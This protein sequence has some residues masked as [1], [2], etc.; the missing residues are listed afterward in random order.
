[1][2][3]SRTIATG[4]V[5]VLIAVALIASQFVS[6][7]GV[8]MGFWPV[9]GTIACVLVLIV[10]VARLR[11]GV[12]FMV[13]LALLYVL[14][15]AQF[16]W[17]MVGVW[18]LLLAAVVAGAGIDLL[19]HSLRKNRW[20]KKFEDWG[21]DADPFH[22]SHAAHKAYKAHAAWHEA[23]PEAKSQGGGTHG[24]KKHEVGGLHL[25][26]SGDDNHPVS[27]VRFGS[28]SRYL[29]SDALSSGLFDLSFG[30][31][32]VFF[33]QAQLAPEGAKI[34]VNAQFGE[35]RLY[36]P[37]DWSV[38][39]S[40]LSVS[41]TGGFDNSVQSGGEGPTLTIEG[42]VSFGSLAIERVPAQ[43]PAG[44]AAAA[45]PEVVVEVKD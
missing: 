34:I 17:P 9:V 19:T 32:E 28:N 10:T 14:W 25:E 45:E 16:G 2:R 13:P 43:K 33:D 35:V 39:T 1:M 30:Q 11:F 18:I 41:F 6:L 8:H 40:G 15:R 36:I 4:L 24:S 42:S 38:N 31:L 37:A 29:H 22:Y 21:G 3:R 5:F 26:S 7:N 44:A 20:Q 12:S 23:H 27:R